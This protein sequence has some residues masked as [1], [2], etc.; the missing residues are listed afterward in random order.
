MLQPPPS[1]LVKRQNV[2]VSKPVVKETKIVV[3]EEENE[4]DSEHSIGDNKPPKEEEG[5]E[6]FKAQQLEAVVATG[7][8]AYIVDEYD[9]HRPN[10]FET[11]LQEREWR[12]AQQV[13]KSSLG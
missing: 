7:R 1:V 6:D 13:V 11:C 10:D 3:S 12:K 5:E 8:S 9:P 4:K 2:K